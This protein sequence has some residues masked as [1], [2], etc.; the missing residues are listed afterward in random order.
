MDCVSRTLRWRSFRN[1]SRTYVDAFQNSLPIRYPLHLSTPVRQVSRRSGVGAS[2]EVANGACLK[3]D[4]GVLAVHANQALSLLGD[5]ATDL[6][7]SILGCFKTSKNVCYLHS[8]TSVSRH[9]TNQKRLSD[10]VQLLLPKRASARVVWN[11]LLASS[12]D[13]ER[14]APWR[15]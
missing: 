3:Y 6:E 15:A 8:D 1:G 13:F 12:Q 11:C 10:V 5:E 7:R 4:H 2:L 9:S 14:S